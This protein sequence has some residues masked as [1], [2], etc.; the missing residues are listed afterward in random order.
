MSESLRWCLGLVPG[1]PPNASACAAGEGERPRT[2][3][4]AG[5]AAS[6]GAG[7]LMIVMVD[8]S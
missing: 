7:L 1:E 2:S 3:V 4:V 5:S 8:P 6:G